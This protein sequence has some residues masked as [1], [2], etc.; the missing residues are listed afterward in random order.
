MR[1]NVEAF[2]RIAPVSLKISCGN[3][4]SC[5]SR[6][7]DLNASFTAGYMIRSGSKDLNASFTAGYVIMFQTWTR[8]WIA[9]GMIL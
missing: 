3:T 7:R 5:G 4:A 2:H 9:S 1:Q 6:S 8:V